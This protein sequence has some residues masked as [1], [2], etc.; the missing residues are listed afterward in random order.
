MEIRLQVESHTLNARV[1]VESAWVK[2]A[3]MSNLRELRETLQEQG[4]EVEQFTVD[5]D[6]G[7]NG[8][9]S[10]GGF[11][12]GA[13]GD[14]FLSMPGPNGEV[15]LAAIQAEDAIAPGPVGSGGAGSVDFF[16]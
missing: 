12:G 2:D 11:K 14:E 10:S 13:F 5:I 1:T 7:T 16:A 4:V 9:K 15:E 6:A 3:V 8:K